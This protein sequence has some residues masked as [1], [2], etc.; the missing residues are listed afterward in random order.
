MSQSIS[1]SGISLRQKRNRTSLTGIKSPVNDVLNIQYLL[2]TYCIRL[3][4][5][6]A[7]NAFSNTQSYIDGQSQK[8][9]SCCGS[10]TFSISGGR[11]VTPCLLASWPPVCR[12]RGPLFA[13]MVTCCHHF[14]FSTDFGHIGALIPPAFYEVLPF[15]FS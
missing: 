10:R 5:E 1:R 2:G 14:V 11:F 7:N 3:S 15:R 4:K 6:Y 12:G 13:H 8:S 9:K